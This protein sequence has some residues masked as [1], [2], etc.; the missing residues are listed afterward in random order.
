MKDIID[1]KMGNL[2]QNFVE[3]KDIVNE[4]KAYFEK[5]INEIRKETTWKIPDLEKLL[6]SRISEQKVEAMVDQVD[7]KVT[8][9]LENQSERLLERLQAS[10]KECMQ[11]VEN[12][13]TFTS[14]RNSDLRREMTQLIEKME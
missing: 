4:S 5:T 9:E 13:V 3:L 10:Y 6:W 14:N 7:K 12:T 2:K 8:A 11:K 1:I